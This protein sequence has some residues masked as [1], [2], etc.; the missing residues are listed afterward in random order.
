MNTQRETM[1]R[2]NSAVNLTSYNYLKILV[3]GGA[4]SASYGDTIFLG[5]STASNITAPAS[6]VSKATIRS[7]DAETTVILN[8]SNYS[9]NYF[10][11]F[12]NTQATTGYSGGYDLYQVFLTS[13]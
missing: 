9:G 13:S 8:V 1:G 5:I 7:V 10:I 12:G 11:Y 2:L 4:S 6:L 3:K